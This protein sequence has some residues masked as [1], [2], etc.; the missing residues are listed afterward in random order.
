MSFIAL[1]YSLVDPASVGIAR[2]L[3]YLLQCREVEHVGRVREAYVCSDGAA[4]LVAFEDDVIY[5]DYLDTEL[6][7]ASRYLVL[8]RHSSASRIPILSVHTPGNPGPSAPYG[9]RPWELPPSDPLLGWLLIRELRRAVDERGMSDRYDVVYEST[10][11][12]PS[13]ISKPITFVEIG[14]DEE[15]WRDA[16]AHR[17]VAIAVAAALEK[18]P[19]SSCTPAVGFGGPHYQSVFT[20]RALETDLCFGHMISKNVLRELSNEDDL[21]RAATLAIERTP[22]AR[23]AILEKMRASVR[24]PIEEVARSLGLSVARS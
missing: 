20:R 9:G 2:E 21:R 4:K 17:A 24:R 23:V 11:H 7:R 8:S 12:G 15:R 6:P 16:E 13:S 19:A 1:V 3:R 14:S 18:L 5:L 10:H 22:G